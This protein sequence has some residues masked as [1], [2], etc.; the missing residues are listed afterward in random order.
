MSRK[1]TL[2][3][4]LQPMLATLTDAPFVDPHGVFED[5]YDGF[6]MVCE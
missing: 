3:K 6:R 5:K 1:S 4:R 2:P